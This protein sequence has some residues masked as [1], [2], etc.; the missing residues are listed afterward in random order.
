MWLSARVGDF[1][2]PKL[3]LLWNIGLSSLNKSGV[4][5]ILIQTIRKGT[6]A[7]EN[8]GKSFNNELILPRA[9]RCA[10]IQPDLAVDEFNL[11]AA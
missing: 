1:F 3:M 2:S 11:K 6:S 8:S 10:F 5:N 9:D 7:L 4:Y